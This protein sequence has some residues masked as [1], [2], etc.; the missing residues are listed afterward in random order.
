MP[1]SRIRTKKGRKKKITKADAQKIL[2]SEMAKKLP[3]IT[4]VNHSQRLQESLKEHGQ[5]GI[6]AY[7]RAVELHLEEKKIEETIKQQID[8]H[9]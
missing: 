1:K 9:R 6:A 5:V 2:I 7:I 8:E 4:G 3:E